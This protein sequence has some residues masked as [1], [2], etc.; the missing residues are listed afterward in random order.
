MLHGAALL[1]MEARFPVSEITIGWEKKKHPKLRSVL[2]ENLMTLNTPKW[3]HGVINYDMQRHRCQNMHF[4][5]VL[6]RG[7]LELKKEMADESITMFCVAAWRELR[8]WS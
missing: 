1:H 4:L 3:K 6:N 2:W 7:L 8:S 5:Q